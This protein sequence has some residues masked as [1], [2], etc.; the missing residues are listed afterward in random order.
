MDDAQRNFM[1]KLVLERK[2]LGLTLQELAKKS[3]VSSSIISKIE[4]GQV[5]PT[6]EIASRIAN[7]LQTT[8]A[9]MLQKEKNNSIE[10]L[11]AGHQVILRNE[12]GTHIR[13]FSSP[14][15]KKM[16]VEVYQESLS[17]D[18][19]ID[20][21]NY[22]SAEVYILIMS[23]ELLVETEGALSHTLTIGDS[24]FFM[25]QQVNDLKLTSTS[26][27]EFVTILHHKEKP[28]N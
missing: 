3:Q 2:K 11:L 8:L 22:G 17:K 20:F 19:V 12:A 23:G 13:K 4:N 14:I 24:I 10:L 16:C 5:N 27:C 18:A 9:V 1:H 26:T 7:G 25:G 28:W 6:I 15:N 21:F